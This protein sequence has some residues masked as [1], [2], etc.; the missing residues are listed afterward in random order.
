MEEYTNKIFQLKTTGDFDQVMDTVT[1]LFDDNNEEFNESQR[2][3]LFDL[4]LASLDHVDDYAIDIL[5]VAKDV[6]MV[7]KTLSALSYKVHRSLNTVLSKITNLEILNYIV[8]HPYAKFKVGYRQSEPLRFATLNGQ[9][10]RISILLRGRHANVHSRGL[11][12]N[13]KSSV[14][15]AV[16]FDNKTAIRMFLGSGFMC[17]HESYTQFINNYVSRVELQMSMEKIKLVSFL[18]DKYV[19]D[20]DLDFNAMLK[21]T[22]D[23]T[24]PLKELSISATLRHN[25]D[26]I[27]KITSG[28]HKV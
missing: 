1:Y 8:T 28:C 13:G 7:E 5:L 4:L 3:H 21:L 19:K 14:E 25:F 23:T 26:K 24:D 17:T 11:T 2:L 22:E 20:G 12:T 15:L 16:M 18:N 10:N 6:T 9:I 27:R